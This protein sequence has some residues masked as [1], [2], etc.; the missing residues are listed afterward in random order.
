[1]KDDHSLNVNGNTTVRREVNKV[2]FDDKL[3]VAQILV[4]FYNE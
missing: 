4:P 1:M 2:D 3:A